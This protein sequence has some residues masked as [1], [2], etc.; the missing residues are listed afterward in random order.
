MAVGYSM[1]LSLRALLKSPRTKTFSAHF[2][3]PILRRFPW[4]LFVPPVVTRTSGWMARSIRPSRWRPFHRNSGPEFDHPYIRCSPFTT[5]SCKTELSESW[6]SG[7]SQ[8][9]IC[10]SWQ[11]GQRLLCSKQTMSVSSSATKSLKRRNPKMTTKLWMIIKSREYAFPLF[12]SN[13]SI[14]QPQ[15]KS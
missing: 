6:S 3:I 7:H 9:A 8:W 15:F 14:L 11:C 1:R 10:S 5:N 2:K 13:P 12:K 4:F